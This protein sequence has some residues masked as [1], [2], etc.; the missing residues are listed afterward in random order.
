MQWPD[1]EQTYLHGVEALSFAVL[2]V[3]CIALS[4]VRPWSWLE[5]PPLRALGLIS[6]SLYLWHLIGLF[7]ADQVHTS[8]WRYQILTGLVA[9]LALATGS[10]LIIERPFD[11]LKQRLA[12]KK[13]CEAAT[14]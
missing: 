12:R 5:L 4:K 13:P 3:Q 8:R 14:M 7:T 9:S 11:R 1:F 2:I 6:Y 10:Y